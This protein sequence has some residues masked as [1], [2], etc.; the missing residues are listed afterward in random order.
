MGLIFGH[1]FRARYDSPQTGI[2]PPEPIMQSAIIAGEDVIAR[3]SEAYAW[4]SEIY[5]QDVCVRCGETKDRKGGVMMGS[6][7]SIAEY[8]KESAE[9]PEESVERGDEIPEEHLRETVPKVCPVCFHHWRNPKTNPDKPCPMCRDK[10]LS[11]VEDV[12][13]NPDQYPK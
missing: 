1:K 10:V 3:V 12:M 11:K 4:T 5:V 7:K 9:E 8:K 13:K 6:P 2:A